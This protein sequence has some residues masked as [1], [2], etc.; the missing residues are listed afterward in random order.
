M[1]NSKDMNKKRV[2]AEDRNT[3]DPRT[4][5]HQRTRVQLSDATR[6]ADADGPD[7]GGV[8]IDIEGTWLV[9]GRYVREEYSVWDRGDGGHVG[10]TYYFIYPDQS[11]DLEGEPKPCEV[12]M[13][14]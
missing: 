8:G 14:Y 2:W 9:R 7:S 5:G 10:S 12:G 1:K 4:G 6:I 13:P 11:V 3:Y